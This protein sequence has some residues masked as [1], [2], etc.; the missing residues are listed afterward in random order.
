MDGYI[1]ENL[2]GQR[3]GVVIV[4]GRLDEQRQPDCVPANGRVGS[5]EYT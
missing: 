1:S 5:H 4:D 3:D 2:A